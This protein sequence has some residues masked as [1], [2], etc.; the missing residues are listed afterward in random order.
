MNIDEA[1]VLRS[2][3]DAVMA[4]AVCAMRTDGKLSVKEISWLRMLAYQSPLYEVTDDIDDYIIRISR[5]V[6]AGGEDAVLDRV[7]ELLSPRMRETAYAW[8][9]EIVHA[10][11]KVV[12]LEHSFLSA[13]RAKLGIHG[14]LAGKLNAAA[15][16]RHRTR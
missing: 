1:R 15:A 7:A 12:P 11:G 2:T 13:F 14:E 4:A 9:L 16:I 10:D 5:S 8:A 3:A 6:I